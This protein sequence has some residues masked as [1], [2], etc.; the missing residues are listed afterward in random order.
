M[1]LDSGISGCDVGCWVR[2]R[3]GEADGCTRGSYVGCSDGGRIVEAADGACEG[4][5]DGAGIGAAVCTTIESHQVVALVGASE[6]ISDVVGVGVSIVVTAMGVT[7]LVTIRIGRWVM[8]CLFCAICFCDCPSRPSTSV[9][10]GSWSH[11]PFVFWDFGAKVPMKPS[12]T[13]KFVAWP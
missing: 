6:G 4:S 7:V 5:E 8:A 2:W 1:D 13:S 10:L 11:R 12:V 3:D 9:A